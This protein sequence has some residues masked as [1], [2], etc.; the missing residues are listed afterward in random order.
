MLMMQ[1]TEYNK[2]GYR[3]EKINKKYF[4]NVLTNTCGVNIIQI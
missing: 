4:K 3:E 1:K 2:V